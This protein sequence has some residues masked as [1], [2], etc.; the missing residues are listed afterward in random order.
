MTTMFFFKFVMFVCPV[1]KH[2]YDKFIIIGRILMF[3]W[4]AFVMYKQSNNLCG[5]GDGGQMRIYMM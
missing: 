5:N 3:Y 2:N 1:I 4:F